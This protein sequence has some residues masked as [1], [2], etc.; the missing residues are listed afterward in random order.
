MSNNKWTVERITKLC[1]EYCGRCD[2]PFNSPVVINSRLTKTL[3]RCFYK[4]DENSSRLVPFKID[5]SKK[6]LETAEDESIIKVIEHE[7]AH[8]VTTFLTGEN[9]NHDKVFKMYCFKINAN[10]SFTNPATSIIKKKNYSP[11][12]EY[13]Y[14]FYCKKCGKFVGGR[15]RAC[16][17]T[18]N[19]NSFFSKCCDANLDLKINW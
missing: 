4:R 12:K 6:L 11:D 13:K 7:C 5:I 10:A 18:K 14:T 9:Y 8:Y 2:V 3:G 16:D 1:I 17:M 19:I 15:S